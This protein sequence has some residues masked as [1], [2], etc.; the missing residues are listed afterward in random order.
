LAFKS[1]DL[2]DVENGTEKASADRVE[3]ERVQWPVRNE[4]MRERSSVSALIKTHFA[5]SVYSAF[6]DEARPILLY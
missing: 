1:L 4:I 5:G 2:E 6:W 3:V